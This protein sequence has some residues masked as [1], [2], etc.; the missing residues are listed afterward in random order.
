ME[1]SNS[2]EGSGA[3]EA[4]WLV[5]GWP[6]VLGVVSGSGVG[7]WFL[8]FGMLEVEVVWGTEVLLG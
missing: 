6:I 3:D 4:L 1:K 8:V 2:D 7:S 5:F